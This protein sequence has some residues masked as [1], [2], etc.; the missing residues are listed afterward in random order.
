[1]ALGV[2]SETL[3]AQ[4]TAGV[5]VLMSKAGPVQNGAENEV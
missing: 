5:Q 3:G 1:M 2:W 4:G